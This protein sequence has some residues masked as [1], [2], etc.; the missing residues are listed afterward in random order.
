MLV[1]ADAARLVQVFGNLLN[2]A[3]KYTEPGGAIDVA[4]RLEDG[5]ARRAV[6]DHGHRHRARAAAA[7]LRPLRA[8]RALARPRARAASASASRWCGTWSSC[9]ADRVRARSD[10]PGR[11]SE[12][13]RP[14][15]AG[16]A[17]RGDSRAGG[18][19]A[20]R[21]AAAR[22]HAPLRILVVD[23]N[24]DAASTLAPS[25]RAPRSRGRGRPRRPGRARA[26]AAH[27]RPSWCSSTSGSPAWTAT[28]SRRRCAAPAS[29]TR[30]WSPS[31]A[32]DVTTTCARAR[33]GGF[34]HHLV[35]PVDL[36]AL[37]ASP[38]PTAASS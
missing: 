20:R 27:D 15:A 7:R 29:R 21:A 33:D 4:S 35:K 8:G 5:E 6:R 23:D 30:R 36:A 9:T 24:V 19:A 22:A 2:N 11:G 14:P 37:G 28:S 16:A 12:I 10:G 13:R 17:G 26:K 25:A 3:A 34:D 31:P 32:T 1:D 18:T 38:R